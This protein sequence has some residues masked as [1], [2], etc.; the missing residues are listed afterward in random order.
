MWKFDCIEN[1]HDVYRGEDCIKEFC[2]SLRE[3]MIPLTN[4]E[5]ELYFNQI[6]CHICK[7]N[8]DHKYTNDKNYRKVK[9]QCHYTG[10]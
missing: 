6:N 3:Q 1:K 9:D 2:K 5:Y 4:E 10:K 7:K 8:F